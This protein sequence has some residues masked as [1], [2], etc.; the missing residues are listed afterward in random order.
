MNYKHLSITTIYLII[1]SFIAPTQAWETPLT[2]SETNQNSFGCPQQHPGLAWQR[3]EL[4]FGLSRPNG[5]LIT[6]AEFK[7][8]LET[9]VT[10]RFK[11]GFTVIPAAGQYQDATGNIL[12][13]EAQILMIF[14]PGNNLNHQ[15]IEAIRTTYKIKFQQESVIRVDQQTCVSF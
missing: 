12:Q 4:F 11:S 6:P 2:R 1:S 14:H 13:E 10:P 7:G 15:A 8:F 3:T 9:E 5:S